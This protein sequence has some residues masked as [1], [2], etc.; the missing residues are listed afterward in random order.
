MAPLSNDPIMLDRSIWLFRHLE[1]QNPSI[2]SDFIGRNRILQKKVSSTKSRSTK[3][4]N[5]IEGDLRVTA[6][7]YACFTPYHDRPVLPTILGQ[8]IDVSSP[9]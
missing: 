1:Y 6:A 7:Q 2:I 8:Y 4:L 9:I 3:N 5:D